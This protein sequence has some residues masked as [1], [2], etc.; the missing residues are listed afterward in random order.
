MA[1]GIAIDLNMVVY[2]CPPS[3]LAYTYDSMWAY[4][5][6]YKVNVEIGPTHAMNDSGVA[7]I[8]MLGSRSFI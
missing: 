7:C 1:N 4:G 6:H 5:N 8:F 2:F 3:T